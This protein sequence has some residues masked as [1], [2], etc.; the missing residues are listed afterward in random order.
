MDKSRT[1][2]V[3][4][5]ERRGPGIGECV[6]LVEAEIGRRG[7][8]SEQSHPRIIDLLARFSDF[9]VAGHNLERLFDAEPNVV[10]E[11]VRT[12]V[13]GDVPA[14]ATMHMRRSAIRLLFRI[15]RELGVATGDPTLD[16]ELPPRSRSKGRPL[17]DDEVAL[18]RSA[19]VHTLSSTRPSASW[20]L[21]EATATTSE[22]PLVRCGDVDL[23]HERVW[24]RGG[25]STAARWGEFSSWGVAQAGR[26]LDALRR[27]TR[28]EP[29]VY[30]GSGSAQS[31]Q[32]SACAAISQV[33]GWAG[34]GN[35]PDLRPASVTAWAGAQ[36][37]DDGYP[38]DEV[39]RRLG[40]RSLDRT[41]ELICW[42]WRDTDG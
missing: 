33:V 24:L 20:A 42:D 37:L 40:R 2:S 8:L 31:R 6:A 25:R 18:C 19:S 34:L 11:F 39:A 26:R 27:T 21:A 32:A 1:Q 3:G 35:E 9:C 22:I 36:L 14:A 16:L 15:G 5:R 4:P 12:R 17:T 23:E 10:E 29:L 28:T 7:L 41:A 13:A 30:E 38:I